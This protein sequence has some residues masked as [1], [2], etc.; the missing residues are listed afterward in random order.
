MVLLRYYKR[1]IN[2]YG[3][4]ERPLTELLNK[5]AVKW[6]R[7]AEITFQ[8]LNEVVSSPLVLALPNFDLEFLI[9]ADTFS[10]G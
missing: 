1:F 9:E 2:N 7:E 10:L 6:S 5:Y 4:I 8:K 3:V